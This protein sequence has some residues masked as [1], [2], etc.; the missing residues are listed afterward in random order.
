MM[1]SLDF[2]SLLFRE[3][4]QLS[5]LRILFTGEFNE[6]MQ[7]FPSPFTQIVII[8]L[9]LPSQTAFVCSRERFSH[10]PL[11]FI[12][13]RE[14][15]EERLKRERQSGVVDVDGSLRREMH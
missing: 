8:F 14:G 15:Q 6:D 9:L 1:D 13:G 5:F 2:S 10:S 3:A 12:W 7:R 4:R 11:T